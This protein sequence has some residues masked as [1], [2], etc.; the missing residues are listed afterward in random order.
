MGAL[1][2]LQRQVLG[3]IGRAVVKSINTASKCQMVDLELLAGQQKAGIEHLEPYG[4]TS[5]ANAGSEAVVLFP[6]GDRSHAV[7][8][9]VSDRRYRVKGLK[10]GEVAFY[11]DQGQSVTLTRSGIVVDGGGK[12]ITFKNAPKARFEMPIEST[13]DITDLCD[14]TGLTMAAMRVAYNG[15]KHN[16]NGN[17]TD[18]PD[19]KMEA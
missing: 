13:G 19:T 6:D 4:F 7:V 2:S 8:I 16:E 9:S 15:H 12:I 18:V 3:L 14:S 11:D 1:Q 5:N 10:T 17:T